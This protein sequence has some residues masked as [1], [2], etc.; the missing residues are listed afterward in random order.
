MSKIKNTN[1]KLRSL[2][3]EIFIPKPRSQT[4]L[5]KINHPYFFTVES[6]IPYDKNRVACPTDAMT[7]S[8]TI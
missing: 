3:E 1:E 5:W 8:G 6:I 4:L 2:M 7:L